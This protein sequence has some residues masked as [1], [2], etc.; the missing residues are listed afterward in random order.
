MT[1][2]DGERVSLRD[3]VPVVRFATSAAFATWLDEH[4]A[5]APGLW[6][7]F[8]K[9][10]R[11][12]PSIGFHEALE[13]SMCLGWVDSIMHRVDDDFYELR[14]QPRGPKS[15]WGPRNQRLAQQL[16]EAGRMHPAGRAAA[17]AAKAEGRWGAD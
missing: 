1:P 13:V 17:D 4:H 14:Y 15:T 6:V 2:T 9:K 16:I 3:N 8:A 7:Q 12:I 10:G 11:G 5:T